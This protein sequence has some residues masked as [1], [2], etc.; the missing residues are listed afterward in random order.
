MPQQTRTG[1]TGIPWDRCDR[2]GQ[3]YKM[4]DLEMQNGL[5]LCI[6]KCLDPTFLSVPGDRDAAIGEYLA[7]VVSGS[8]E[9]QPITDLLRKDPNFEDIP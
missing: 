3:P 5:L 7:D 9:G 6:P 4:D 8:T 1:W 2:C